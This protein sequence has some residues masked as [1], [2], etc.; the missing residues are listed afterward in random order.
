[1]N[2]QNTLIRSF[3]S[4]LLQVVRDEACHGS[5]KRTFT[6]QPHGLSDTGLPFNKLRLA[7]EPGPGP[8]LALLKGG[9]VVS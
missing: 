9:M 5:G 6:V 1:M 8:L 3:H 7:D 2:L 4:R